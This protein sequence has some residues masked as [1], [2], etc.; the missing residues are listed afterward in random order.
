MFL[1]QTIYDT[2]DWKIE[3]LPP[4]AIPLLNKKLFK[5]LFS[6]DLYQNIL[7]IT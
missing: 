6:I 3:Y 1:Y 7:L 2:I 4:N 5:N